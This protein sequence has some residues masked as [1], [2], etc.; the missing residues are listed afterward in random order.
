M[1]SPAP[2]PPETDFTKLENGSVGSPESEVPAPPAETTPEE[3]AVALEQIVVGKEVEESEETV[4]AVPM[5]DKW[6]IA[7]PGAV[8]HKVWNW[9][10]TP[11]SPLAVQIEA[12]LTLGVLFTLITVNLW[13]AIGETAGFYGTIFALMIVYLLSMILGELASRVGTHPLCG[14]LVAGF[15]C[16]YI[17]GVKAGRVI[18]PEVSK[19]IREFGLCTILLRAGVALDVKLLSRLVWLCSASAIIPTV[20][21]AAVIAALCV[22]MLSIPW[23]W[24]F[25]A[26]F[27]TAGVAPA[28]V[29][30]ALLALQDE[31]YGVEKG[32]P[33]LVLA[34]A[35]IDDCLAVVG[36]A[37]FQG[38]VF[39]N[40][41]IVLSIFRAPIEIALGIVF[42]VVIGLG[43]VL[44]LPRDKAEIS[45]DSDNEMSASTLY[46]QDP[47]AEETDE[48]TPA[49]TKH[50][51]KFESLRK[52][53]ASGQSLKAL[54]QSGDTQRAILRTLYILG[55]GL[56]TVLIG[57]REKY[58]GAGALAIVVLG[59]VAAQG[60][61][62]AL[63]K[64]PRLYLLYLWSLFVQPLLF[65]VIGT[66]IDIS[67][68]KG[69]FLWKGVIIIPIACFARIGATVL[70]ASGTMLN[71]G[72]R[73]FLALAWLPKATVQAALAPQALSSAE[74]A[75][76]EKKIGY[77][78]TVFA[79]SMLSV[80]LTAPLGAM[81]L[82]AAGP[83]LLSRVA[84][85]DKLKHSKTMIHHRYHL[86][87]AHMFGFHF[88]GFHGFHG[89]KSAIGKKY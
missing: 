32:I 53:V 77:A 60:W 75:K 1:A 18:E 4:K 17:P 10:M 24:G 52:H 51:S 80:I 19:F 3:S 13:L 73:L 88:H 65:G 47:G 26:G 27:I 35:A 29:V 58:S 21:E 61:G 12:L 20:V 84:D 48:E 6:A 11:R 56:W 70:G 69:S 66:Q 89:Y 68:F 50:E 23:T 62:R 54:P 28:I 38:V 39:E 42:G 2:P 44:L 46:L 55:F 79:V 64:Q 7:T 74:K 40:Q 41:S 81:I 67:Y 5:E 85:G 8:F 57:A 86:P 25:M 78:E 63:T 45:N 33:S 34:V 31:G 83:K 49:V 22:G 72:E 15:I 16:R 37:V 9:F 36:N 43:G 14:M 59:T 30:P 87:K 76:D 71:M 82:K